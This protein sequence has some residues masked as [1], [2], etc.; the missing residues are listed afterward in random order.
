[1]RQ[2]RPP[3][4]QPPAGAG[5]R[6][7]HDGRREG[8][9]KMGT[10]TNYKTLL[11][12]LAN[13][14][15]AYN[16]VLNPD[17]TVDRMP[18]D[19]TVFNG[20]DYNRNDSVHG[21]R[22][23]RSPPPGC[24]ASAPPPTASMRPMCGGTGTTRY[25]ALTLP[26]SGASAISIRPSA[27]NLAAGS[28][29]ATPPRDCSRLT[30]A[31]SR[32]T[33]WTQMCQRRLDPAVA[34]RDAAAGLGRQRCAA[35]EPQLQLQPPPYAGLSQRGVLEE[36][37]ERSTVRLQQRLFQRALCCV[38]RR[39]ASATRSPGSPGTTGPTPAPGNC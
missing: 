6:Q 35:I 1:M 17:L 22:P 2:R 8:H 28:E 39:T 7:R 14:S 29:A 9:P 4:V 36:P 38:F 24:S 11:Q 15:A 26:P 13:P 32:R 10:T 21:W 19:L 31:A 30:Q 33:L 3:G 25:R 37:G 34:P 12:R 18:V 27:C 20:T 16:A 5:R 23:G